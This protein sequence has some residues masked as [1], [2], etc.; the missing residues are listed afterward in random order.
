MHSCVSPAAIPLFLFLPVYNWLGIVLGCLLV[1]CYY[2]FSATAVSSSF[3][4]RRLFFARS[5]SLSLSPPE[6]TSGVCFC[7]SRRPEISFF[8]SCC[9]CYCCFFYYCNKRRRRRRESCSFCRV[10][11]THTTNIRMLI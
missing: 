6:S 10:Y 9:C 1:L 2:Y 8:Y 7:V 11:A 3:L 5:V 4:R